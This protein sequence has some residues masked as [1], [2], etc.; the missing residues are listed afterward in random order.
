MFRVTQTER[1]HHR[2]QALKRREH[3]RLPTYAYIIY[4]DNRTE[5]S[6]LVPDVIQTVF[7]VLT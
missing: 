7:Q 2:T 4:K 1:W 6:A 3:T 5:I